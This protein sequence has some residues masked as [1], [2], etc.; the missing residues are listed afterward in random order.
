MKIIKRIEDIIL[1]E[2]TAVAIG[3]FDGVHAGHRKLLAEL[4]LAKEDGLKTVVF[5]FDPSPDALFGKGGIGQLSTMA[6]KEYAFEE[7]GVDVLIEYP[8]TR[9]SAAIRPDDFIEEFLVKS[10]NAKLIIAGPDLSFGAGGK[11]DFALLNALRSVYGY[12]TREIDKMVFGG[13]AISSSRIRKMIEGGAMEEADACLG[14]PYSILGTVTEGKK[15]GREL[16]F[17]TANMDLAFEK[18][19]PPYGV[20]FAEAVIEGGRYPALCNIGVRPTVEGTTRPKA[21]THIL[22]FDK[23]IYG[24]ELLVELIHYHRP[25]RKFASTE[26]LSKQIEKDREELEVFFSAIGKNSVFQRSADYM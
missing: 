25:E 7:L 26:E 24:R 14:R 8:L 22:F 11:G 1:D 15:L 21:E 12:E 13:K 19:L 2:S 16:G 10:L 23:N 3:K 9:D 18:V 5:T 4:M 20:Y 17:P 6:E